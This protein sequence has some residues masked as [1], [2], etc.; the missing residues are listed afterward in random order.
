VD[1]LFGVLWNAVDLDSVGAFLAD[2]GDEGLFWEVKGTR[3]NPRTVRKSVRGFANSERGGYLILGARQVDGGWQLAGL[4]FGV[5]EPGT[6][7]ADTITGGLRPWPPFD[8]R[9]FEHEGGSVAVVRVEPLSGAPCVTQDG[10]VY[11]RVVGKT[12]PITDPA[13]LGR[14]FERGEAARARAAVGAIE[15]ATRVVHHTPAISLDVPTITIFGFG[16]HAAEHAEG[17]ADRLFSGGFRDMVRELAIAHLRPSHYETAGGVRHRY[18]QDVV[19]AIISRNPGN[20]LAQYQ[21]A[22]RARG[23]GSVGV[24]CFMRPNEDNLLGI[25]VLFDE[26]IVPAWTVACS[27]VEYLGG[28]GQASL[29]IEHGA[30]EPRIVLIAPDYRDLLPAGTTIERSVP[31]DAPSAEAVGTVRDEI[32]RSIGFPAWQLPTV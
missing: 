20:E 6:W 2:A 26:I 19:W 23:D 1:D 8:I 11:L 14:L 29:R 17:V 9:V 25:S 24:A 22:I 13:V 28:R 16:L 32:V 3:P 12:A 30:T 27:A 5:P 21:W 15:A 4:D 10:Q 18:E 31:L 7:L